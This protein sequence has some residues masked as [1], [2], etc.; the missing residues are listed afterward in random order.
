VSHDLTFSPPVE[1]GVVVG[2]DGS[3]HAARALEWAWEEALSRRTP[4]HVVR[5]WSLAS[6]AH[7]VGAPIGVVPSLAECAAAVTAQTAQEIDRMRSDPR[8]TGPA[9]DD[10]APE[11][12]VHVLHAH[13]GEALVAAAAHAD[14]VVVGHLG[15]N[16][17]TLVLGSVA[18]YVLER[19]RCPVVVL[20]AP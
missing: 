16:H 11:L 10:G 7:D 9:R 19:A 18:A 2:I 15:R 14:L 4:L 17:L 8:F 3:S 20:P 13:P 6:A 5:A 12:H 1:G